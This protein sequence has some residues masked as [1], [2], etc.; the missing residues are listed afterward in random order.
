MNRTLPEQVA[1]LLARRP[2]QSVTLERFAPSHTR[3]L[4][5]DSSPADA[6]PASVIVLLYPAAGEW[7]IPLVLRPTSMKHHQGQVGFPGGGCQ[8]GE[9]PAR[10]ALR[11]L[12][13]EL[14]VAGSLVH[15]LGPLSSVFVPVSRYVVHPWLA[16][17]QTTLEFRPDARE[18]SE[19]VEAPLRPILDLSALE[20]EWREIA[21]E[22]VEVP[23]FSVGAH[24]VWGLT[25][26][27]LGEL[28]LLCRGLE[29]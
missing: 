23:F 18:V 3:T 17:V 19:L 16:W 29:A 4:R 2:P 27:I 24:K 22:R 10:A 21:G 14:G 12:E 1:P 15:L 13:E 7:H 5:L 6:K 8:P 20:S 28:A 25:C 11:E 26:I 9:D